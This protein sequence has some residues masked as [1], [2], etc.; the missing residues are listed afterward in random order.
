MARG[1]APCESSASKYFP[2]IASPTFAVGLAKLL[3]FLLVVIA[4]YFYAS[5]LLGFFPWTRGYA[6]VLVGYVL[7]PLRLIA[8]TAVAYLPNLFFIAGHYPGGIL[9]DQVH[10]DHL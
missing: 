1:S 7:S 4:L 3:R 6:Q 10:Q 8:D 5:L 9:F 2:L